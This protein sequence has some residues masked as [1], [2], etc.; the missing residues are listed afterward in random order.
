MGTV[1]W[2]WGYRRVEDRPWGN[3]EQI[4]S[5][6]ET[7][8]RNNRRICTKALTIFNMNIFYTNRHFVYHNYFHTFLKDARLTRKCGETIFLDDEQP[9][10]ELTLIH[11][12]DERG[13]EGEHDGH[14]CLWFIRSPPGTKLRLDSVELV[15]S[16]PSL[17]VYN[18]L[19]I[20]S[21]DV[22]EPSAGKRIKFKSRGRAVTCQLLANSKEE[23]AV[24][25]LATL[26]GKLFRSF[27]I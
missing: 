17:L 8:K 6:L 11:D 12:G 27:L 9:Q 20:N 26:I 21:N 3:W 5:P 19:G 13:V 18:G 10:V 24:T 23:S 22:I 15:S 1:G 7:P 25:L 4:L 16:S 14:N 2:R